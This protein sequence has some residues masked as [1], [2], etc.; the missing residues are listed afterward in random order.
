M[1]LDQIFSEYTVGSTGFCIAVETHC[2]YD[3]SRDEIERIGYASKTPEDF[4]HIFAEE[5]WWTDENNV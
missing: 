4:D 2:G 5:F 1:T 3:L